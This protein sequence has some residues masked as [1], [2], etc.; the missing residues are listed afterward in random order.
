MPAE[1]NIKTYRIQPIH[2]T[3]PTLK[4]F[5]VHNDLDRVDKLKYAYVR[6]LSF[7]RHLKAYIRLAIL[8]GA[9]THRKR[10]AILF[11]P[12]TD[13]KRL[14]RKRL[15]AYIHINLIEYTC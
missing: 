2:I 15:E 3:I 10:Q 4:P 14:D 6:S 11:G 9:N 8:F 1:L 13:I 5:S 7:D 12:N